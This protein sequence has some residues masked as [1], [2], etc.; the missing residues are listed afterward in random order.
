MACLHRAYFHTVHSLPQ[1]NLTSL[2]WQSGRRWTVAIAGSHLRHPSWSMEGSAETFITVAE[3]GASPSAGS[4]LFCIC[5]PVCLCFFIPCPPHLV[6]SLEPCEDKALGL[7][8]FEAGS[9]SVARLG[10][11][12]CRLG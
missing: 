10:H 1:T 2:P 9:C 6:Q 5:V 8:C 11:I 12:L 4:L 3:P 7:C